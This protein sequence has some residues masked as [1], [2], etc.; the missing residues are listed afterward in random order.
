MK[1]KTQ[2]I[3]HIV[4]IIS[5]II[6]PGLFIITWNSIGSI[7]K[8]LITGNI[9]LNTI[10]SPLLIILS[11]I[12][13]T[14]IWGRFFCSYVCTFGFMHELI[15]KLGNLLEVKKIKINYKT[16]RY[17]KYIKYIII[18]ISIII[19]TVDTNISS[20]SP[21]NTFGIL[22]SLKN[23]SNLI[24]VGGLVL[25][26]IM[27]VSL[28]IDRFFCRY[29]CPL[30]GLF[31]AISTNRLFKIKKNKNCIGCNKCNRVCPMNINVNNDTNNILN[32][33]EC[34]DCF[35]CIG[36][37][38]KNALYTTTNEAINGTVAGLS[39]LGLTYIGNVVTNNTGV[40]SSYKEKTTTGSFKDGTYKGVG[41]GYRGETEVKVVVENGNISSIT[42]ESY[43]DDTQFFNKAKNTIINEI[44]DS[45]STNVKTVSGATYS[46]KGIIDAVSNALNNMVYID[47]NSNAN[48]NTN[49]NSNTNS[50]SNSNEKSNSN[51]NSNSSTNSLDF[52]NL[53]DGT[54]TGTGKGR[55]GNIEVT[56]KVNNSKVESITINSSQ[57]DV[58]YFNRASSIIDSVIDKQS[59]NVSKVSG[60]TMS[61]NGILEAI[62]NALNIEYT[63]T[64]SG[65]RGHGHRH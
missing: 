52:N 24:S 39:I 26:I 16:D 40:Q 12:P 59:L 55:N 27:F 34:I 29:L 20:I 1:N 37:C 63:N 14:I 56:V 28:F 3:R 15:N 25:L 33:G 43:K 64:N 51:S 32:S 7:Y 30:G 6:Y 41:Q 62:A 36:S 65:V 60:A 38:P 45:Q 42:I 2:I 35:E 19:W 4:Q 61:S 48:A 21:W 13:I 17:L 53:K 31:S 11:I 46:S 5:A 22:V 47:S 44:I 10:L 50:N 18:L 57:E 58:Q 8:L 23:Y 54:Y 9:S 49:N